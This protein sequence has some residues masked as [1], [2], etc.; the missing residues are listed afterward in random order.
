L[1]LGFDL[2]R[3]GLRANPTLIAAR[4]SGRAG[5]AAYRFVDRGARLATYRLQVVDLARR[6]SW[7]G[8]GSAA[9]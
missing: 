6:R 7:Y 2:Y 3:N 8:V 1:H 9:G 4:R 5:G